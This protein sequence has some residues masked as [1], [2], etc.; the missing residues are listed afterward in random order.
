MAKNMKDAELNEYSASSPLRPLSDGSYSP[1]KS[2]AAL[3]PPPPPQIQL[4]TP[5]DIYLFPM[6]VGRNRRGRD[7]ASMTIQG[8]TSP[9]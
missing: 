3:F 6:I 8:Y 1:T 5:R 4:A 2:I 7:E 9:S